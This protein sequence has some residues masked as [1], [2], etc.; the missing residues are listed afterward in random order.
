M[1]EYS[2]FNYREYIYGQMGEY[3]KEIGKII[4]CMEM[5]N[6]NGKMEEYMKV[7]Q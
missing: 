3:T 6:I 7:I 2:P 4:Q 1:E 5:E